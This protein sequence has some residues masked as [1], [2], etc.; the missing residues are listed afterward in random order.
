VASTG[1]WRE[2]CVGGT[3]CQSWFI[4]RLDSGQTAT[5]K[6][7]IFVLDV[8][9]PIAATARLV[10]ATP[11]DTIVVNNQSTLV[12]QPDLNPMI[13]DGR[14][15]D[16]QLVNVIVGSVYPNPTQD[17]LILELNS[18][19]DN[20]IPISF[21]N[22]QGKM[23]LQIGQRLTKG[24]NIIPLHTESLQTGAYLMQVPQ[25]SDKNGLI[26]FIKK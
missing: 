1:I 9:T 3:Q 22:M 17:I 14:K 23:M 20:E 5:L 15:A 11:A 24:L 26:P 13:A 25:T 19:I 2:W 8:Q 10:T 16:L 7:P 4:N 21:F 18:L 6:I 12:L